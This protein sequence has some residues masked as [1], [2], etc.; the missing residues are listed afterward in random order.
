MEFGDHSPPPSPALDQQRDALQKGLGRAWQWAMN[1]RLDDEPL[2]EACL[3]DRRF[4][5]QVERLRGGWL[6]QLLWAAGAVDRFRVPILHAL[7]D[8]SDGRSADQLCQLARRYAEEGD[9]TFR[10]RLYEIVAE[11]PFAET[12][13]LGEEEIVGLD[14]GQ[15]FLFA[16]GVRGQLLAG[17]QWEWDGWDDG[18]LIHLAAQR[19]GEEQVGSLLEACS[20]EAVRRFRESWR[21][22]RQQ[23]ADRSQPDSHRDR[24]AAAPAEGVVRA[25]EADDKC[26]WLRGWGRHAKDGDLRTVLQ[27]LWAARE[28]RVIANLL[29]VFSA[30]ALPAFDARLLGLCRH[31]DEA[32]R[33]RAFAALAQNAHPL[34]R[35]FALTQL[36]KGVPDGSVVALFLNNYHED[37]ERRILEALELPEDGCEQ[38]WLL[39]DVLKVLEK[40]PA[41][42]CSRLAALSYARTPC[43]NCR[44][45]AARLLWAQ[46]A[47]PG[48]LVEECRYDSNE[49]CRELAEKSPASSEPG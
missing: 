2:L 25:A 45:S 26:F 35:Q 29:R 20:D 41:A 22:A 31:G 32:V 4:D 44:F 30:R 12:P 13:W 18:S 47:A 42:D 40:N 1:G 9:E 36:P 11:K 8:L 49:E 7:Y 17:G 6:W 24:M 23:Q 21:R 14:G 43:E 39:M 48:W 37:D 34:V 5:T 16:A 15:G 46:H 3:Q 27:H 33:R 28:P 10:A 38:H 19:W